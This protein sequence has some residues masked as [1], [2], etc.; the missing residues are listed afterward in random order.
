MMT[1]KNICATMAPFLLSASFAFGDELVVNIMN[2]GNTHMDQQN[3]GCQN[4]QEPYL[5]GSTD[6]LDH[7]YDG[8]MDSGGGA[9]L[10]DSQ[11]PWFVQN[12]KSV[13]YCI[14]ADYS[15]FRY[16]EEE[17]DHLIQ[18]AF[19]FWKTEFAASRK[20]TDFEVA[21]QNFIKVNCSD[22]VDL[23]FQFGVLS[24]Q[25]LK[26]HG[27]DPREFVSY[28]ALT[29][30]DR[31]NLKGR[32][33]IYVSSDNGDLKFRGDNYRE[34][35]WHLKKGGYLFFALAHELGHVFGVKHLEQSLLMS[36]DAL[37][38]MITKPKT[39][40]MADNMKLR[41][42]K[43]IQTESERPLQLD[44]QPA[45]IIIEPEYMRF[46]E[47]FAFSGHE[48]QK[49]FTA[50]EKIFSRNNPNP[51]QHCFGPN[52]EEPGIWSILSMADRKPCIKASLDTTGSEP[53]MTISVRENIND[54]PFREVTSFKINAINQSTFAQTYGEVTLFL[55]PQQAVFP[56]IKDEYRYLRNYGIHAQEYWGEIEN[57][58]TKKM[59][60]VRIIS[61]LDGIR[62]FIAD[63]SRLLDIKF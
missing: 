34:D 7:L 26:R 15:T 9:L 59:N 31:V 55:T 33:Y 50:T 56:S 5:D 3:G 60:S 27:N 30:Y 37:E 11:N 32:G 45:R 2:R 21:T 16:S 47:T 57:A 6:M 17:L 43:Y 1:V 41:E 54:I 14:E 42:S 58:V 18:S 49:Y 38:K 52:E 8:G 4:E 61:D 44:F 62:L 36:A 46:I 29:K 63:E 48:I 19:R 51:K 22:E 39:W 12:I 53:T 25:Q 10:K 35:I 40:K 28:A 20:T 24:Q 13:S 23:R